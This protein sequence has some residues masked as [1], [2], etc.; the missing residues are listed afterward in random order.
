MFG[1]LVF[2]IVSNNSDSLINGSLDCR[3]GGC[4]YALCWDAELY[5]VAVV[6][7]MPRFVPVPLETVGS[8]T[9]FRTKRDFG[10]SALPILKY[11]RHHWHGSC[12]GF[13][14]SV[15]HGLVNIR[16][17]YTDH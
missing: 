2:G 3:L 16:S 17:N 12:D 14:H 1:P 11:L 15:C 8:M 9:L 7:H 4:F 5:P 10:I 6:T 13:G